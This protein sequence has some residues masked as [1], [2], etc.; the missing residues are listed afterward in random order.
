MA[1]QVLQ[2]LQVLEAALLQKGKECDSYAQRYATLAAA[3]DMQSEAHTAKYS[4]Q[5]ATV[6]QLQLELD[7]QHAQSMELKEKLLALEAQVAHKQHK[8]DALQKELTAT[9]LS[10]DVLQA[11]GCHLQLQVASHMPQTVAASVGTSST[12]QLDVATQQCNAESSQRVSQGTQT[13]LAGTDTSNRL[14]ELQ[15]QLALSADQHAE[16]RSSQE[17]LLLEADAKL[18]AELQAGR[19]KQEQ[20]E[21]AAAALK[22]SKACIDSLE[23]D[24]VRLQSDLC[25][26]TAL[27]LSLR[28]QL[29]QA[30]CELDKHSSPTQRLMDTQTAL[31]SSEAIA[32]ELQQQLAIAEEDAAASTAERKELMA[33]A[34][35]DRTLLHELRAQLAATQE[36]KAALLALPQPDA[37]TAAELQKTQQIVLELQEQLTDHS[38]SLQIAQAAAVAATAENSQLSSQ[39]A[40]AR[41]AIKLAEHSLAELTTDQQRQVA[42][43]EQLEQDRDSLMEE[44]LSAKARAADQERIIQ[45]V[46]AAAD[47]AAREK[48]LLRHQLDCTEHQLASQAQELLQQQKETH[49]LQTAHKDQAVYLK[50][51][52]L[53]GSSNEHGLRGLQQRLQDALQDKK[54]AELEAQSLQARLQEAE[55]ALSQARGQSSMHVTKLAGMQL[56]MATQLDQLSLTR[57]S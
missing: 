49:R 53:K 48:A 34:V 26:S 35:T 23:S 29:Q 51:A 11:D 55:E 15:Q 39:L 54:A 56:H 40:D 38:T 37:A 22:S 1:V 50:K 33:A 41:Q 28:Q 16:Y 12:E 19:A 57:F 9:S 6:T 31:A 24:I 32:A 47:A 27:G 5:A 7:T 42:A 45:S 4:T 36:D 18:R 10:R 21:G 2:E 44:V 14:Q 13:S 43:Q 17:R 25:E 46:R 3:S 30:I 20:L 8:L 52:Q